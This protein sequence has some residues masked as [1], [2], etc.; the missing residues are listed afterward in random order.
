MAALH[1]GSALRVS[2]PG[3]EPRLDLSLIP[4]AG[5][6]ASQLAAGK[7]LVTDPVLQGDAI[8][9]DAEREQIGKAEALT[10]M[11]NSRFRLNRAPIY[12]AFT[13]LSYASNRG[14]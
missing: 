13:G 12:T 4:S 10:H 6:R 2:R 1:D 9:D 14:N 5:I 11:G 7:A 8:F 3:I